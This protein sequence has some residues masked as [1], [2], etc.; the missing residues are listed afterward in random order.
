MK[1]AALRVAIVCA[2]FCYLVSPLLAPGAGAAKTP[3]LWSHS[4][5]GS[6]KSPKFEIP[7]SAATKWM[8]EKAGPTCA[9]SQMLWRSSLHPSRATAPS[10]THPVT[11]ASVS[12]RAVTEGTRT[13]VPEPSASTFMLAL[14]A[15]GRIESR[16]SLRDDY[17]CSSCATNLTHTDAW[18][19]YS[20]L[21]SLRRSW[22]GA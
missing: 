4:G 2:G 12:D 18:A 15:L 3:A 9:R 20:G 19:T 8:A 13:S 22:P 6:Y 16:S 7:V 1:S 11:A 21:G 10:A 17:R 5:R 14:R